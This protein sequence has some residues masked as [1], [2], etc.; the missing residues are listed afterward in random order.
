MSDDLT[1][2]LRVKL[3]ALVLQALAELAEGV[4]APLGDPLQGVEQ[5]WKGISITGITNYPVHS[6]V[7]S[8]DELTL[9]SPDRIIR[10]GNH[11]QL[12]TKVCTTRE[13]LGL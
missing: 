13:A 1:V 5:N 9:S 8:I 7:T 6:N 3:V 11:A 12:C 10:H 4:I 2:R